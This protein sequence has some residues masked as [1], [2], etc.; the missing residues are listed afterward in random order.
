MTARK[1]TYLIAIVIIITVALSCVTENKRRK[2]CETCPQKEALV[3]KD[4]SWSRTKYIHD[5][6]P[7]A[8]PG[9]TIV[10]P[11]PCDHLCDGNGNLKPFMQQA[12]LNGI[13]S[14]IYTDTKKNELIEECN[15]DSLQRI[16]DSV[17]VENN[18]LRS[19][20]KTI[21]LPPIERNVLTK[22]Q[23]FMYVSAIIFWILLLLF[24]GLRYGLKIFKTLIK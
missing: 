4:T 16:V 7:Y 14:K 5:S 21:T 20:T 13:K 22:F 2:M 24:L 23:A 17:V 3:I 15:A 9:P 8:I 1:W 12:N 10:L 18:H 19:T 11:G 6:I